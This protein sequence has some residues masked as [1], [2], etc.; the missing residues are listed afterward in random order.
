MNA[1]CSAFANAFEL[2][3]FQW[4][5]CTGI[6]R[7]PMPRA[8]SRRPYSSLQNI[9]PIALRTQEHVRTGQL[10]PWEC[11]ARQLRNP[12][13]PLDGLEIEHLVL[14]VDQEMWQRWQVLHAVDRRRHACCCF[15]TME[16]GLN[17]ELSNAT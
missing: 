7:A 9:V 3:T 8:A 13:L 15:L 10:T 16:H 1:A 11:K 4:S 12:R 14:A 5:D 17:D 6:M 2:S